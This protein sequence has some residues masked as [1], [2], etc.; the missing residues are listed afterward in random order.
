MMDLK[1]TIICPE[2]GVTHDEKMPVDH[3]LVTYTCTFCGVTL[4][5]LEGDCCVFCSFGT[6]PCPGVHEESVGNISL[7]LS[8]SQEIGR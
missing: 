6:N 3:C 2:C 4:N 5:P 7:K 1:S 8:M